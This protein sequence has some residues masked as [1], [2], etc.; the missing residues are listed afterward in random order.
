MLTTNTNRCLKGVFDK[1]TCD[2]WIP[3][4]MLFED[5]CNEKQNHK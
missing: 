5:R 1:L 4:Q 2:G 3:E